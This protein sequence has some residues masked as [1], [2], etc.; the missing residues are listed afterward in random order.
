[1]VNRI[2]SPAFEAKTS[3]WVP[4]FI[5]HRT[6]PWANLIPMT[7][8]GYPSGMKG[9]SPEHRLYCACFALFLS[10][11]ASRPLDGMQKETFIYI[12]QM[13]EYG[14]KFTITILQP[15]LQAIMN[16]RDTSSGS[17]TE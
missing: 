14:Q 3:F 11:F 16:L 2:E 12:K 5:L 6:Q 10:F 9:G 4:Q 1:M 15:L 17:K 7:M 8:D 13:E